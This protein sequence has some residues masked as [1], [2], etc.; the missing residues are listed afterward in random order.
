MRG[1]EESGCPSHRGLLHLASR[2][3]RG[4][5]R[6]V[7]S[8]EAVTSL[9]DDPAQFHGEAVGGSCPSTLA[10]LRTQLQHAGGTVKK[11][12]GGGDLAVEAYK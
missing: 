7:D 5:P 8:R 6:A 9:P 12:P 11:V 2:H 10:L 1:Q 3:W 4:A